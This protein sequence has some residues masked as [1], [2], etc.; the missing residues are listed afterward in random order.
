MLRYVVVRLAGGLVTVWAVLT[1]VFFA[2]HL[3]P[4]DPAAAALA[5][6]A[7][8]A[9][10]LEQRRE[11]LDLNRPILIQYARYL[12]RLTGGDPGVSWATGQQVGPMVAQ[13]IGPTV[14]LAV[15]GTA[16][17][18]VLGLVLG[19]W[20]AVTSPSLGA[21]LSRG[22][23]GVL[24]T[25]P[26]AVSGL[27]FVAVFAVHLRWLPATGQ[28][29]VLHLILPALAVGLAGCGGFARAVDAGLT[30]ILNQPFLVAA[31]AKGMTRVQAIRR[32]G[33]RLGLLPTLDLVALQ[34]GY[35]LSGAVITET[36][37][38]RQGLGRLIVF[39]VL[40]QDL[41]VVQAL[42]ALAA[43]VYALLNFLA[44]LARVYIDPRVRLDW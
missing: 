11:A 38:A 35:L 37:F 28:G 40:N 31:R 41:P 30:Q 20:A 15:T 44:D 4:G 42:V 7:A 22:L 27:A 34:L 16:V 33:L 43:A 23:T 19:Y 24:L 21:R 13:Q 2:V 5:Q 26:I 1:L 8:P 10:V 12:G 3:A 18:V 32:H 39:A 6:S 14:E 36:L 9:D 29:T 25:I 17:A